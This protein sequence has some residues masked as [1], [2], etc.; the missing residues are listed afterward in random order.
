MWRDELMQGFWT[1]GRRQVTVW[2]SYQRLGTLS[3]I[4]M[5]SLVAVSSANKIPAVAATLTDWQFEPTNSK[6]ELIRQP[7]TTPRQFLLVKSTHLVVDLPNLQLGRVERKQSNSRLRTSVRVLRSQKDITQSV[8]KRSPKVVLSK[9]LS[10]PGVGS[11]E[12]G[13]HWRSHF[14]IVQM[15]MPDEQPPSP[16]ILP[17]ANLPMNQGGIVKVPPMNRPEAN[18]PST[19]SPASL[20]PTDFPINQTPTPL[21]TSKPLEGSFRRISPAINPVPVI[22]FGQPLPKITPA[23]SVPKLQS[24]LPRL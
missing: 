2:Q 19:A 24:S 10:L 16:D 6:L 4:G 21:N 12:A 17:P 5:V 3:F 13:N 1:T 15:P 9:P 22:E 14:L 7:A 18:L 8:F 23:K 11:V 20:P